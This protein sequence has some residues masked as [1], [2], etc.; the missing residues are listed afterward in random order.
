MENVASS[1]SSISFNDTPN[2]SQWTNT[3]QSVEISQISDEIQIIAKRHEESGRDGSAEVT[4]EVAMLLRWKESIDASINASK[5]SATNPLTQILKNTEEI[6]ARLKT[7]KANPTW[8]Q[9]AA[10]PTQIQGATE[11]KPSQQTE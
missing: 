2:T 4:V 9:I 7:T 11:R 10:L 3:P 5:L 6:R 1:L 8:S